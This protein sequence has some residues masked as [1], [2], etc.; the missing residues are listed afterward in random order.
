MK[1]ILII[2]A[3]GRIGSNLSHF[4]SS[5]G[6][7]LILADV[8]KK[9]LLKLRKKICTK[10]NIY[11][12]VGNLTNLKTIDKLVKFS[13]KQFKKL[14]STIC[15]FYP[16]NKGFGKNFEKLDPN[17]LKITLWNLL[18][19]VIAIS[20]RILLLFKKQKFGNLILLSSILG[21]RSPKFWHY[22]NTNMSSSI[23]Y[24]AAKSAI[25]SITAYMAKYFK[26]SNIRVNSISPGGIRDNQPKIFQKK[27][28][29]SSQSKGL[30][31]AKDIVGTIFFL[32]SDNSK[33]INGQNI[34][35]D[36][37]WSL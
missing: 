18:G 3:C 36:D 8:N 19:S 9:K 20:Q 2:G 7:N 5:Q 26:N 16:K 32:M 13:N 37:G 35:I 28:K 34:I 23:E 30:L 12:F 17:S 33:H 24:S 25:I 29:L 15:C 27:Y 6:Y 21:V 11:L 10:N 4:L 1:N 22:H 31:E 14:D